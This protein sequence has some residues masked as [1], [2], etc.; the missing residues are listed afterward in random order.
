MW[1]LFFGFRPF[2]CKDFGKIYQLKGLKPKN[3][4]HTN[5]Y[6]CCDLTIKVYLIHTTSSSVIRYSHF[7]WVYYLSRLKAE[8]KR[9]YYYC[10]PYFYGHFWC[11]SQHS[12]TMFWNGLL[13]FKAHLSVAWHGFKLVLYVSMFYSST[14]YCK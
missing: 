3:K 9:Y 7:K 5:F 1:P 10:F 8:T 11:T 4:G 6:E 2:N 12:S 14:L 13:K